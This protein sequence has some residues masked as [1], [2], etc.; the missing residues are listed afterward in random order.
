L[1]F[2]IINTGTELLLGN[3]L[4]THQQWLCQRLFEAGYR[5]ERQVS[6][7]DAAEAIHSAIRESLA[8][9][10]VVI[11]TGG[12]GPTSDDLTRD[13]VA[14]MLGRKL[15]MDEQVRGEIRNFFA[16]RNRPQPARTEV[17]ALVP[18][19]ARV[20]PNAVGTAPGLA[21]EIPAGQFRETKSWLFMLPGPPR[22]LHP[23]F[24]EHA[25]PMIRSVLPLRERL[26]C[27]VLRT[28]GIGES[29]VEEKIAGP[30]EVLVRQGLELGYCARTG[31][32]DVRFV[33]PAE[34]VSEAE[35]I[36]RKILGSYVFGADDQRIEEVVVRLL[37]DGQQTLGIAESCTGG[38]INHRIT[39]VPGASR[40]LLAGLVTYSND[41]KQ[42]FLG[43][44][45]DSLK[46]HGAVSEVVAREMAGGVRERVGADF[47][48]SVTGIAGPSGG[49]Q[50]K[51][52]GTVFIGLASGERLLVKKLFNPYD[53]ETF[54]HVTSQQ[55]LDLLRRF[56]L[57]E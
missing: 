50:E 8:R 13:L 3:V 53:R 55:A 9:A 52:V 36:A 39:N 32:V 19:G 35:Q 37:T 31:E 12:L 26:T 24:I 51:P 25:L 33:G 18:E 22:E 21:M 27:R 54:K 17:Q 29:M 47:G 49:S 48:L 57:K 10:D 4:N 42:K 34:M 11:C 7:P 41:A 40:A 16:K 2:E 15:L 1:K 45:A 14:Q 46:E 43:V 44:S 38:L 20:L 6:V 23:M 5:V 28:S 30:L 56:V